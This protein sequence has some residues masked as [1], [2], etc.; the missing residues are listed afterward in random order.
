MRIRIAAVILLCSCASRITAIDEVGDAG[1]RSLARDDAGADSAARSDAGA[2]D[3]NPG[4]QPTQE[5]CIDLA[6]C[7]PAIDPDA[8]F[9]GGKY[10]PS[11]DKIVADDY[12]SP[13]L[14][15]LET[16]RDAGLCP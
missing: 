4:P 12:P 8:G 15:A 10:R 16:Y 5:Q 7:C 3:A 9:D 13:C 14:H 11:C 2:V 6:K 1:P